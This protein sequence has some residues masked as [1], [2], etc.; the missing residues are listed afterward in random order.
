MLKAKDIMTTDVQSVGPETELEELSK[1]FIAQNKQALPV[2]DQEGKLIGLVSQNDLVE[3]NKPL[4]IPTVIS[5]FDWVF[6]LESED[7]FKKE[8]ERMSAR[9][10][11]EIC[12][13][14]VPTCT[15]ETEVSEIAELMVDKAAHLV[16]VLDQDEKLVGVVARLDI[17]RAMGR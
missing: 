11:G 6:Y 4:H 15:A 1:L 7:E 13:R 8:V 3:R 9:T 5:L 14:E 2:I 10:V 17:I 16:P 12:R